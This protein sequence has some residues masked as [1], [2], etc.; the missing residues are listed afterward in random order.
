SSP[1]PSGRS[2]A[3]GRAQAGR[4]PRRRWSRAGPRSGGVR[5]SPPSRRAWPG[6]AKRCGRWSFSER[7]LPQNVGQD[8]APLIDLVVADGQGGQKP[9]NGPVRGVDEQP[10]REALGDDLRSVESQLQ[11]DHRAEDPDVANLLGKL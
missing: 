11:A 8:G 10:P 5:V 9:H 6:E 1:A 7:R 3:P 2:S 4:G